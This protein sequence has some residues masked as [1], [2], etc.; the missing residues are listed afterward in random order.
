[1]KRFAV[2]LFL[3]CSVAQGADLSLPEKVT[4]D[5]GD[6]IQVPATTNGTIVKW[7]VI[8]K[9]LNLF[10]TYLLNDTKTAVVIAKDTGTYRILAYTIDKD[11]LSNPAVCVVVVVTPRPGPGSVLPVPPLP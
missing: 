1:M 9:G 4:G 2:W 8:D 3:I 10:P 11:V 7:V 5:P 6:Y